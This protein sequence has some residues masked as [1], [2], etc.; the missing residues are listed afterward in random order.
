MCESGQWEFDNKQSL[1]CID[2]FKF[3]SIESVLFDS[4]TYGMIYCFV[5]LACLLQLS[6]SLSSSSHFFFSFSFDFCVEF[7]FSSLN[8]VGSSDVIKKSHMYIMC[9][10]IRFLTH[11]SYLFNVCYRLTWEAWNNIIESKIQEKWKKSEKKTLLE[12]KG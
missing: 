8:H 5:C 4:H 6:S 10:K 11:F 1:Y 2:L 9:L 7:F 3:N 12:G